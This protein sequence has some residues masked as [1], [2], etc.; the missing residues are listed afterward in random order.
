MEIAQLRALIT[1]TSAQADTWPAID[2]R[3]SYEDMMNPRRCCTVIG[4]H[5]GRW[6]TEVVF[7]WDAEDGE[8][9]EGGTTGI[10]SLIGDAVA[11]LGAA[12]SGWRH[13]AAA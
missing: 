1:T 2:A 9:R 8:P 5:V 11:P 10:Y 6:G 13:E 3:F 4:Y 7:L 12:K